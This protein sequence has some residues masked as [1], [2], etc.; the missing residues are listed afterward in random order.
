[1]P[2]YGPVPSAP[3]SPYAPAD[4]TT[5]PYPVQPVDGG[6][7]AQGARLEGR[8]ERP[9]H[10]RQGRA[11]RPSECGAGIPAGTPISS[12]SGPTSPQSASTT[13]ALESE[14]LASMAKQ[15][16]GINI[17]LQ[18][19]TFNFLTSNYNN[20]EPG[21]GQVHQR[22]GREQLRRPVHGLLPDRGRGL[23]H[24]RRL[25]HSAATATRPPNNADQRLGVRR[26]PERRSR[27]RRRTLTKNLPVFFFPDQDYLLAVNTKKVGGPAGRLDGDDPAAVVPPVLVPGQAR[28]SDESAGRIA[29]P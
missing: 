25:Q 22:L 4:A 17:Q 9:D 23:Q 11:P 5:P 26:R 7:A 8:A 19:K 14:A 27:P 15:A 6:L 16:A 2:A 20:A 18:T 29:R 24:R 12:S 1:M 13:G 10:L 21:G 28:R 3:T